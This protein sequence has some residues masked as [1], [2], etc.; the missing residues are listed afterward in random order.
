MYLN[1]LH[2]FTVS[3][4]LIHYQAGYGTP[5]PLFGTALYGHGETVT[6]KIESLVPCRGNP[7]SFPDGLEMLEVDARSDS[8]STNVV[9]I[10]Y[11]PF[12]G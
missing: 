12:T 10:E 6:D 7:F 3:V 4:A 2:E 9:F 11:L 8:C 5:L 1:V